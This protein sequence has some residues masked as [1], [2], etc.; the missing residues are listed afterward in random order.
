MHRDQ[1]KGHAVTSSTHPGMPED[2]SHR[3]GEQ[4]QE[5]GKACGEQS[6]ERPTQRKGPHN[7]TASVCAPCTELHGDTE[8]CPGCV[9]ETA[10]KVRASSAQRSPIPLQQAA[11]PASREPAALPGEESSSWQPPETPPQAAAQTVPR[12]RHAAAPPQRPD[13]SRLQ[14]QPP[15]QGTQSPDHPLEA[16][17]EPRVPHRARAQI[18]ASWGKGSPSP[19][20]REKATA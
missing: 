19:Q 8:M 3:V 10:G 9:S 16:G 2:S 6:R 5:A 7:T 11:A 20:G 4:T 18:T 1:E 14:A 17:R 12:F 15:C 13:L